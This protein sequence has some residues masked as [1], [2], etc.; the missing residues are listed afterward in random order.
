[1]TVLSIV[2]FAVAALLLT[3]ASYLVRRSRMGVAGLALGGLWA[4]LVVTQLAGLGTA[5]WL[6]QVSFAAVAVCLAIAFQAEIRHGF[7]SFATWFTRRRRHERTAPEVDALIGAVRQMGDKRIGALFVFPGDQAIE[8]CLSGGDLLDARISEPLVLSL[9]DPSSP[10]HD[11]AVVVEGSRL[12]RFGVHLPLSADH[13][14]LGPGG[15]RHAA[16]LGLAERCDALALVVSEERGTVSFAEKGALVPIPPGALVT[17]L[18]ERLGQEI[19]EARRESGPAWRRAGAWL[20]LVVGAALAG[21]LWAFVAPNVS[22]AERT[23]SIPVEVMNLPDGF[24]LVEARPAEVE[25]TV[26]GP[27]IRLWSLQPE[28]ANVLIDAGRVIEGRRGFRVKPNLVHL[29]RSL[30]VV[31]IHDPRVRLRV[32]RVP[33]DR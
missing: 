2:D 9:F 29:P 1:M 24:E 6:L 28:D 22:Q 33:G 8:H 10:G 18:R 16:A 31:S 13:A 19:G 25:I 17:T 21:M 7:E 11:G 32:R 30:E 26:N 14:A 12:T 23:L 15:T 27:R 5:S 4:L 20:D 3:A